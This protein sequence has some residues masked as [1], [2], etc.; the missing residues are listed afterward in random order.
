MPSNPPVNY[1]GATTR[2]QLNIRTEVDRA[3][4]GSGKPRRAPREGDIKRTALGQRL[5]RRKRS[6]GSVHR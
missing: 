5:I 3:S 2:G 6:L 1:R 4:G